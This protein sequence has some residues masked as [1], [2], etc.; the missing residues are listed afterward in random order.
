MQRIGKNS[1]D[2][3]SLGII[4]YELIYKK[5]PFELDANGRV[6]DR[7]FKKFLQGEVKINFPATN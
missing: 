7:I 1:C 5:H 4:L 3:W 2:I 6:K